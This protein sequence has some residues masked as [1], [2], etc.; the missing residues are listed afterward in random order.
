MYAR[1][2]S[3]GTR[4]QPTCTCILWHV[5]YYGVHISTS[6]MKWCWDLYMYCTCIHVH[7]CQE[8]CAYRILVVYW[9]LVSDVQYRDG[10]IDS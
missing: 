6:N 5:L 2:E 1:G 3:L 4:L 9:R 8:P 10:E 7:V